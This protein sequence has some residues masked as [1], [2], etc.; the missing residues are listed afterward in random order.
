MIT[1]KIK[2]SKKKDPRTTS[3]EQKIQAKKVTDEY[4]RLYIIVD[5]LSIVIIWNTPSKACPIFSKELMPYYTP[6]S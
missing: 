5:Q 4:M 1:A 6:E 2:F 3:T